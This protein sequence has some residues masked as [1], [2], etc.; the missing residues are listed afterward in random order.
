MQLATDCLLRICHGQLHNRIQ[1]HVV[2]ELAAEGC[3]DL[4][5]GKTL[6]YAGID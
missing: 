5:L 4:R 6:A 1:G 2:F 3:A